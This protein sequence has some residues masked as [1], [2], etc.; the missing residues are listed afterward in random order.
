MDTASVSLPIGSLWQNGLLPSNN[1]FNI[2][3]K[4]ANAAVDQYSLNNVYRSGFTLPDV[5]TTNSITIEFKTNNNPYENTYK[6]VDETGTQVLGASNLVAANTTYSD[7]YFLVGCYK[8]I[9]QDLGGDGLQWWANT[10]QGAGTVK[11]RVGN[12]LVLKNFPTDFG[13]GFEYS[14]TTVPNNYVGLNEN[15]LAAQVRVFPNPAHDKIQISGNR[16]SEA[17]IVL[18]DVLGRAVSLHQSGNDEL[19][20]L[21]SSGLT[22]GVYLLTIRLDGTAVTKKVVIQ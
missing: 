10:A 18:T 7:S 9:V 1:V 5:L 11:I 17:E 15:K 4:K 22:P 8:L 3:I 13:N 20:Q 16:L 2:E 21:D 6:I 19:R 12:G 14:F